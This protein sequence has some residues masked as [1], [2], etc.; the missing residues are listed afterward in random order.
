MPTTNVCLGLC[1]FDHQLLYAASDPQK[2]ACLSR[3]GAIDFNFDVADAV[4]SEN[5]NYLPGLRNTLADLKKRFS[6][7]HVRVLLYPTM[8]C[9]TALPK[10]VYDNAEEREAH[11]NILMNGLPRKQIHPV[12][13]TLS[14]ENFK[15]LQ[16]R[17]DD[18][19]KGVQTLTAD[20][21][22]VDY[23]SAFEIGENWIKHVRPG[24]SFLTICCFKKCISVSS[25]ILGKLRGATYIQFDEPEDLP[26]LW[27]QRAQTLPW[28]QG[29]HEQ[30]QVYGREAW[31]II[32]IL[33]PFWDEAGTVTKMDTLN[34]MQ[35]KA[36]EDTYGFDLELAYPAIMLALN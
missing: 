17:T 32:E 5:N 22:S 16:L 29:L 4:L 26:Y 36:K 9:W 19:L 2:N 27:L 31:H 10:L 24:G 28:M 8:E 25:F 21:S 34:K 11:I 15:L 33:Q 1:F 23:V 12:W 6:V 18:T 13:H 14:N 7:T 35:V 3:I 20:I 30:I